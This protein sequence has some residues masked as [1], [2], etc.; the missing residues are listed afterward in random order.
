MSLF[1]L[2]LQLVKIVNSQLALRPSLLGKVNGF[3]LFSD[4]SFKSSNQEILKLNEMSVLNSSLVPRSLY[5]LLIGFFPE[6]EVSRW[7][8]V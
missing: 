6:S 7:D 3:L 4:A 8:C 2:I 5:F 1:A